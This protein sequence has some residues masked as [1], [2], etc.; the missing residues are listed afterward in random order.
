[1]T[2]LFCILNPKKNAKT[3]ELF[4]KA[5]IER[6]VEFIEIDTRS[7][8]ADIV[9][10]AKP[11]KGDC[12]YRVTAN[13]ENAKKLEYSLVKDFVATF[14][15][16]P[17]IIFRPHASIKLE[18][19]TIPTP[20]TIP[21][22]TSDRDILKSYAEYLGGFPLIIKAMGKQEGAGVMRVDS[23]GSFYSIADYL[24]KQK[25]DFLI[26]EYIDVRE[27]IRVIVLG[28]RVIAS[29]KYK[30]S[31]NEDFRSNR[32]TTLN[33]A[34]L[35]SCSEEI[36]RIAIDAVKFTGLEYGGVDILIDDKNKP[37]VLEINFPCNF[38]EAQEFT[39]VDIAG[40]M[41][42]YLAEKAITLNK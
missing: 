25:G 28:D 3:R 39:K 33:S 12:L 9:N 24:F 8:K 30:A 41:V 10:C 38:V 15:G 31:Y 36:S 29:M 21:V 27:S 26:R 11:S 2:K 42:E 13:S 19:S 22:I 32:R 35:F 40:L 4:K 7:N 23:A 20:K 6:A 14:Y 34:E 16:S 37:Y 18:K 17:D 5:C 1:M